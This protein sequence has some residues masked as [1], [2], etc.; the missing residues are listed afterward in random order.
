MMLLFLF[1]V[2]EDEAQEVLLPP[3]I[4]ELEDWENPTVPTQG[5]MELQKLRADS[6]VY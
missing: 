6:Q 1:L 2:T 3:G 5:D 4:N